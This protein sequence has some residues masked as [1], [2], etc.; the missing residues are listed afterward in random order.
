MHHWKSVACSVDL[1]RF[2]CT[3]FSP[4]IWLLLLT[5][6]YTTSKQANNQ[7]IKQSTPVHL[8]CLSA[9][10]HCG[11]PA[12]GQHSGKDLVLPR[13]AW[14][15]EDQHCQ[16]HSEGAEPR[17]MYVCMNVWM[18][19]WILLAVA[20]VLNTNPS[21]NLLGVLNCYIP[22]LFKK[23]FSIFSPS[24]SGSVWAEWRM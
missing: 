11:E 16:V 13:P 1:E 22:N 18:Y 15:R 9:G 17:G 4:W 8:P 23:S 3:S 10:I 7:E 6:F 20:L 19:E 14:S 12:E 2:Y 21:M 5:W 24:I